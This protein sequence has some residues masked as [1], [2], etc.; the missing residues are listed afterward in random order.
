ME[1]SQKRSLPN[2]AAPFVKL[3]LNLAVKCGFL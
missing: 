3:E 1:R 2:I